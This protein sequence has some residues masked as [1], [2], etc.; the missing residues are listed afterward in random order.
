MSRK[1]SYQKMKIFF[2]LLLF[3]LSLILL[4]CNRPIPRS[5]N[6]TAT[7]LP[8]T[9]EPLSL[10]RTS[11]A[12]QIIA[13][14]TAAEVSTLNPTEGPTIESPVVTTLAVNTE[15]PQTVISTAA[16]VQTTA[17]PIE[18]EIPSL[19][20]TTSPPG[21]TT[22]L[23]TRAHQQV[24]PHAIEMPRVVRLHRG[25]FPWCI[26]RRYDVNPRQLMKINGFYMGQ[27]FYAGQQVIL[28]MNPK[29]YPGLRAL[30]PH[31]TSYRVAPGDTIYS[32]AC[33][34]GDVDPEALAVLNGI[35]PPYR[36]FVGEL[37]SIP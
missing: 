22:P 36:L 33:Y 3:I 20:P 8:K 16:T 19:T 30:R 6:P 1:W 17:L 28:P 31:P 26:A 13:T 23:P 34:F 25:E 21:K 14:L 10:T 7:S 18:T 24:S 4:S 11:L 5:V 9:T 37:L 29:P 27:I 12:G 35:Q 15:I 32:I 2:W